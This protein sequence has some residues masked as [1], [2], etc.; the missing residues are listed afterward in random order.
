MGIPGDYL[1]VRSGDNLCC[2]RHINPELEVVCVKKGPFIVRYE[3]RETVLNDNEATV[4]LPY[5]IH[6]F[7]HGEGAD[8]K[9]LMFSYSVAEEFY[10]KYRVKELKKDRFVIPS[11][12][13]SYINSELY[14]VVEN[15]NTFGIKGIFFPLIAEYLKDNESFEYSNA[16]GSDVRMIMDYISGKILDGITTDDVA[17]ATGINKTKI[18]NIFKKYLGL[19]FS[20]FLTVVRV[21]KAYSMILGTDM[22]IT[23]IAYQCGF[24]SVRNFNRVFARLIKCTPRELRKGGTVRSG[25]HK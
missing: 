5:R 6:G 20:E 4:I 10:N 24:G 9:I 3:D 25:E 1:F 2:E 7:R 16:G 15:K 22:S 23:D 8:V 19:S 17:K 18:G 12:L 13:E 11:D 21:E 14:G